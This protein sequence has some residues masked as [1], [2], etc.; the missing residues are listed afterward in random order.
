LHLVDGSGLSSDDRA[1]A[2]TFMKY[3][4][5]FPGTTQGHNF[6][7]LLPAN[8]DGTL[9]RLSGATLGQGVVR[10]KTGTLGNVSSLVGY[11]GHRDGML[12][13]SVIYNG[14]RVYSAKQQQ[15]ALFKTL[16]A[17]G[18]PVFQQTATEQ[19]GGE[20]ISNPPPR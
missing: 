12:V 18:T 4:A 16:G 6:P 5:R 17:Q 10:A 9:K 19:V 20:D 7:L 13:V 14:G 1:T 15:W 3:L 8:G 2:Y 11:L